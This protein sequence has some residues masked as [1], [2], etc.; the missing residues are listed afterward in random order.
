[1]ADTAEHIRQQTGL[2]GTTSWYVS[3]PKESDDLIRQGKIDLVTLGRPLLSDPHWPYHAAREL[4]VENPA[5]ATLPASYA[6][7]LARYR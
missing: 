5:W 6:H 1:M 7:W 4:G 2:P 3:Q